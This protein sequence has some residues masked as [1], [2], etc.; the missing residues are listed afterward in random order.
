M[1]DDEKKDFKETTRKVDRMYDMLY[2]N[3]FAQAIKDQKGDIEEI[4]K[5]VNGLVK[6]FAVFIAGR[7]DTCPFKRS[8]KEDRRMAALTFGVIFSGLGST[9][10]LVV[11]LFR[12]IGVL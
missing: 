4:K 3:G 10:A 12:L 7:A 2:A 9:T 8:A 1:T 5:S 11:L 6:S